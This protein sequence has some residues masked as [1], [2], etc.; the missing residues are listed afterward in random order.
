M[1]NVHAPF[2]TRL[3]EGVVDYRNRPRIIVRRAVNQTSGIGFRMIMRIYK[4]RIPV[5]RCYNLW[6]LGT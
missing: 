2:G 5:T 3:R 6:F 1:E 4:Y